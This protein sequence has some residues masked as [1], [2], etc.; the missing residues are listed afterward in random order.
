M[1]LLDCG[2]LFEI[3]PIHDLRVLT[4]VHIREADLYITFQGLNS[5]LPL[6]GGCA[7]KIDVLVKDDASVV[8]PFHTTDLLTFSLDHHI[9]QVLDW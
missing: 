1:L 7:H 3:T 9:A 5:E 4:F 2:A 8:R 6:E